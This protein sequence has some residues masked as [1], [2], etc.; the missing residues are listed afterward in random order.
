[1]LK[2][3]TWLIIRVKRFYDIELRNNVGLSLTAG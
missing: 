2:L 1:M 3:N